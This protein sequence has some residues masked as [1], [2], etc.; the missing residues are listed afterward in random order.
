LLYQVVAAA[1]TLAAKSGKEFHVYLTRS[2]EKSQK[3]L[4]AA[5]IPVTLIEDMAIGF[6]MN[7]VII[8]LSYRTGTYLKSV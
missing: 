4:Q 6:I 7:K 5:N 2:G 1:L 8:F 3:W